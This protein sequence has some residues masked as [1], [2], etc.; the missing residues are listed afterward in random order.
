MLL[1]RKARKSLLHFT[2]A[3]SY[4]PSP[5]RHHRVLIGALQKVLD[6]DLKRLMVFMPPGSA[7]STYASILAPGGYL[8]RHP[9][10][11]RVIAAS[12]DTSLSTLFGRRVRNM[13]Q[14]SEYQRIF[15]VGLAQDTK[16]KGEWELSTGA[17]YYATGVGSA[18]TGRRGTLGILDDIIKG[19]KEADSQTIRDATWEWYKADFRTRFVPGSSQIYIATRWH[20]DDPAGRILGDAYDG[21]SGFVTAVDGEEWYVLSLPAEARQGD[22]VGREP[23][24]WLWPEWFTPD[25]WEQERRT[26]GARNWSALYQ[27]VPSPDEGI[28]FKR[29][30]FQWYQ[31]PP[32]H[33]HYYMAGD[34]AVTEGDGDYTEIGVAA[35]DGND[36]MYLAPERGWWS[37]QT[38]ADQWIDAMLSL[39]REHQPLAFVSEKGVI[40]NAVEPYILKRQREL[41]AYVH[42]EWLPHVGDKA[43]NARAFQARASNGKVHLPDN[44]IGHRILNQL[45]TFP[46]GK[47]DDIVDVCGLLGRYLQMMVGKAP[48]P[49]AQQVP[50]DMWGRPRSVNNWKTL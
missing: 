29:E 35:I 1:R 18:V 5:A 20:E 46:A 38:P 22:P 21:S 47:H 43:A 8:G 48:P 2:E 26:Q 27:Q 11:G 30:W 40:R 34:F 42:L 32:E 41:Q 7:K 37:G 33:A 9:V 14:S 13:V 25:F 50:T 45:L 36:D 23:G 17:S 31:E 12:Y 6:G 10:E 15:P 4:E 44:E 28:Y 19:R 39:V 3:V 49:P 24:E 16:A